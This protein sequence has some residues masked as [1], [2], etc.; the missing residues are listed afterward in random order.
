MRFKGERLNQHSLSRELEITLSR[1]T[2]KDNT[3]KIDWL[4]LK[5]DWRPQ[6]KATGGGGMALSTYRLYKAFYCEMGGPFI[7]IKATFSFSLSAPGNTLAFYPLP[8]LPDAETLTLPISG[9]HYM[10]AIYASTVEVLSAQNGGEVRVRRFDGTN[11][12]GSGLWIDVAGIYVRDL[13]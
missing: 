4:E 3:R 13:T 9:T 5:R 11:F 12:T 8:F 6:L 2:L 1:L 7:W 10:G